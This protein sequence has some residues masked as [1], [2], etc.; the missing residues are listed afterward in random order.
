MGIPNEGAAQLKIQSIT[1]HTKVLLEYLMRSVLL[2]DRIWAPY[3][4]QTEEFKKLDSEIA[5]LAVLQQTSE[6]GGEVATSDLVKATHNSVESI[7]M[8]LTDYI[9]FRNLE[10]ENVKEVVSLLS[11]VSNELSEGLSVAKGHRYIEKIKKT[12]PKQIPY[13]VRNDPAHTAG[14][15]DLKG[16]DIMNP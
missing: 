8:V 16:T 6:T 10:F 13:A 9:G 11:R 14:R 1:E 3:N 15:D 5:A 7:R 12:T 2:R 4:I